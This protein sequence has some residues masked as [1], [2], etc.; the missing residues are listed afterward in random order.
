MLDQSNNK[1]EISL[2]HKQNGIHGVVKRVV[3]T[4]EDK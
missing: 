1:W 3:N 2:G 4:E